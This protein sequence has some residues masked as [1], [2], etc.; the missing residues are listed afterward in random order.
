MSVINELNDVL[1]KND[2][3]EDNEMWKKIRTGLGYA[4]IVAFLAAP[5]SSA[6]A[7]DAAKA[8]LY[9]R[10]GGVYAIAS[11]VDEFIERLLVNDTLNANSAIA[12]A[13]SAVPKAGLKYQVTAMVAWATGGPESYTGRSML[14]SHAHLGITEAEWDEMASIFVAVLNDFNVPAAEQE[15]L[16]AIVGTTKADIVS[17]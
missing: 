9:D 7:D 3:Q 2:N 14:E 1:Y 10:L 16:L 4:L 8:S 11:V 6:F 13:R 17:R 15:E 5:G 12:D